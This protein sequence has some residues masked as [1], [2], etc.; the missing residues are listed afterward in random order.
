M[1]RAFLVDDAALRV[2]LRR[3]GVLLDH[4]DLLDD[5][6][7]TNDAKDLALL[8]LVGTGDDDDEVTLA[9]VC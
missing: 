7:V 3:L 1:N 2:L 5:H 6:A 8:A 9:D 4:R